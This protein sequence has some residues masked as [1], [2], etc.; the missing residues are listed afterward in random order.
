MF[1]NMIRSLMICY[2]AVFVCS[3][4][5]SSRVREPQPRAFALENIAHSVVTDLMD[6]VEMNGRFFWWSRYKRP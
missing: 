4:S 6:L 3:C 5:T 1:K 2:A